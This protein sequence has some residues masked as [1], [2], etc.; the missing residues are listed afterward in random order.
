M[1]LKRKLGQT[2]M[3]RIEAMPS[4]K[5]TREQTE[6]VQPV[7]QAAKH[8]AYSTLDDEA[9]RAELLSRVTAPPEL[10][11]ET[12]IYLSRR[13]EDYVRD[14]AYRL[15][16][17]AAADGSVQPVPPERAEQF[18]REEA[19]GRV[20]MEEAFKQLTA[21]EPALAAIEQQVR[22][23]RHAAGGEGPSTISKEVQERLSKLVGGGATRDDELLRST[24]AGSL[25]GQYLEIIA[26]ATHLGAPSESFFETPRKSFVATIPV[27]RRPM[28][29][30]A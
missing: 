25:A 18:A 8:L 17:A 19:L 20:S 1:G 24:L 4:G 26:G 28:T 7:A 22:T 6:R 3:T 15:V 5:A 9:A 14:R 11:R 21:I 23:G 30:Q 10:L 13:R 2:I 29:A 16:S 27:R 12:A